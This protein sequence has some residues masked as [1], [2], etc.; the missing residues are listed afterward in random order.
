MPTLK[1]TIRYHYQA[2]LAQVEVVKAEME[3]KLEGGYNTE[4][5]VQ[6][7]TELRAQA[8][9]LHWVLQ[10]IRDFEEGKIS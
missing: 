7:L 8:K 4:G 1:Q 2:H 5:Y 3:R 10:V 9:E 6:H